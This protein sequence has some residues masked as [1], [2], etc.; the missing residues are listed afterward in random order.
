[1]SRASGLHWFNDL[2]YLYKRAFQ[3]LEDVFRTDFKKSKVYEAM[4]LELY[5]N[6]I[7]YK[8]LMQAGLLKQE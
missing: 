3:E 5:E 6:V 4:V 2:D 7:E 1:M 8:F